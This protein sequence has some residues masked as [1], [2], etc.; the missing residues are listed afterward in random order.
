MKVTVEH[1]YDSQCIFKEAQKGL[2]RVVCRLKI[3]L[4]TGALRKYNN[5]SISVMYIGSKERKERGRESKV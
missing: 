1:Y 3:L 4:K 2:G 5:H